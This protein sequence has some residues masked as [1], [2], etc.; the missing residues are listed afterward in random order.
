[1][2]SLSDRNMSLGD[3]LLPQGG[4]Q[5]CLCPRVQGLFTLRKVLLMQLSVALSLHYGWDSQLNTSEMFW[6][7]IS[8]WMISSR[9]W[10]ISVYLLWR[11]AHALNLNLS[12]NV[13]S[14]GLRS[15]SCQLPSCNLLPHIAVLSSF[16]RETSLVNIMRL[17]SILPS[18]ITSAIY[19]LLLLTIANTIYHYYHLR[20]ILCE[21]QGRRDWQPLCTRWEQNYLYLCAGPRWLLISGAVSSWHLL[22]EPRSLWGFDPW[23]LC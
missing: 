9:Y 1:M 14:I 12:C 22:V 16:G 20:L 21:L 3:V 13:V 2:T 17:R 6:I 19:F 18:L 11:T 10:W 23:H 8:R 5:R 4:K 7:D 15:W